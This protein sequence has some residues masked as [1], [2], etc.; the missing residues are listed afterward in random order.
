MA[1]LNFYCRA[2]G[3]GCACHVRFRCFC[4]CYFLAVCVFSLLTRSLRVNWLLLAEP[5]TFTRRAMGLLWALR[6]PRA[7]SCRGNPGVRR[8][9][10]FGCCRLSWSYVCVGVCAA[11]FRFFVFCVGRS[12]YFCFLDPRWEVR[13]FLWSF[14]WARVCCRRDACMSFVSFH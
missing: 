6:V 1:P 8:V 14:D 9:V 5:A 13:V 7:L 2:C 4:C 11:S 10:A 12:V 3:V